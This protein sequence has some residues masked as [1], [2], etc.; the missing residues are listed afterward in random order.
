MSNLTD[1]TVIIVTYKTNYKILYNCINSIHKDIKIINVEN[2]DNV[3]HKIEIEK[4]YKNVEVI[5]SGTNLGYGAGNNLGIKLAKTNY[6]LISNP[7]TVYDNKFFNHLN[8]YLTQ[9]LNFSIIGTSYSDETY[10]PYGSFDLKLT[11]KMKNKSYD[12][13][14]LKEVDWVVGCSMIINLKKIMFKPLFDENIFLFFDETDLCKRVKKIDGKVFNS[15]L[16]IVEHLGHKSSIAANPENRILSEKLRNWH[17]MW[18]SFYYH[19]KHYS[20][21]YSLNKNFGKLI[22]SLFKMFYFRLKKNE[23]KSTIY[24][25]R[26]LGLINSMLGKKSWYR[27]EN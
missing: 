17:Y 15:S 20:Y 11:N 13:N 5:L 7:D 9:E 25:F 27:I 14:N 8:N 24:K 1:L 21:L 26:F 12:S 18:S 16:L 6:I 22:R 10:L 19:K 2:S 3:N 23:L 4:K